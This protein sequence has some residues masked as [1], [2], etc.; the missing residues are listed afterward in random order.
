MKYFRFTALLQSSGWLQPAYVGVDI[1]G[2]ICYVGNN[3]P[4]EAVALEA[5]NGVALPGFPNAHSHAFQFAMAGHAE[6]HPA[7]AKDDFWTWREA[8]YRCALSITPDEMENV[9]YRCYRNMALNGYTHVAEFH[10]LHHD[11]NGKPYA[12]PAEMGERLVA[13]AARSGIQITLIPVFYQKGGFGKEALPEQRRFISKTADEYFRLLE[14]SERAV[15]H[16]QHASLGFSVHSLRAA[17]PELIKMIVDASPKHLPFH[18]HAA[19]QKREVED[20]LHY[21]QKRPVQWIIDNLPVDNRFHLVHCTHLDDNEVVQLARTE[22][23]VVLCPSTEANLGD[24]IFRLI[25]FAAAGG[26]FSIGTDSQVCLNPLEDLR[27]LDYGQRLISHRRNTFHD[28]GLTLMRQVIFSGRKAMGIYSNEFFETGKPMDAVVF[29]SDR[30]EEADA[31]KIL[32]MLLYGS[33]R[34]LRS[35]TVIHGK[36]I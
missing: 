6:T 17:D 32:P 18:M 29:F 33:C 16:Y 26:K 7:G 22:A 4:A 1:N 3:P 24:G 15:K 31:E 2:K 34:N 11:E 14:A 19:E 30:P 8:M 27:W 21:L 23:Q 20:C 5:V 10:Y 25:D 28:G 9:A 35:Q 36:W 12:N 13:A